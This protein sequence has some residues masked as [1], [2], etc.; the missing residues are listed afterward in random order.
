MATL[1]PPFCQ[2]DGKEHVRKITIKPSIF[3]GKVVC[4]DCGKRIVVKK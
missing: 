1:D 2:K 3:G 4:P